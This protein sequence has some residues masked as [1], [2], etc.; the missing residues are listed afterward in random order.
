VRRAPLL[1]A[2][3]VALAA[4][5]PARAA[6]PA[7]DALAAARAVA[8]PASATGTTTVEGDTTDATLEPFE[9]PASV[10]DQDASYAGSIWFRVTAGRSGRLV[11]DTCGS[12]GGP[13]VVAWSDMMLF[14]LLDLGDG[15]AAGC[16]GGA[17][18]A[19]AYIAF[20]VNQGVSYYVAVAH[21]IG[22]AGGPVTLHLHYDDTAPRLVIAGPPPLTNQ[23]TATFT[24]AGDPPSDAA[25]FQCALD[26]ALPTGCT[27]AADGTVTFAGL[28]EG[29]HTLQARVI[30]AAGNG[31]QP[32]TYGWTIDRTPPE[33]RITGFP[34]GA[35]SAASARI[36]FESERGATFGCSLDSAP[37]TPCAPPLLLDGL[38][39]GRHTILVVASDPAGNR[40]PSPATASWVV[41][42]PEPPRP[43]PPPARRPPL[44]G[45]EVVARWQ[46]HGR[47]T[48]ARVLKLT[49]A[50][51]GVTVTVR[52]SGA[53]CPVGR[54]SVTARRRGTLAVRPLLE[55]ASPRR[56][57]VLDVTV[58]RR[59]RTSRIVRYRFG[60]PGTVPARSVLCRS[61]PSASARP[62]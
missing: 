11:A 2:L 50:V 23:T 47:G 44:V 35:T 27:P 17:T 8:A 38:A 14:D 32:T 51:R 29:D 13:V 54:R 37:V 57:A 58:S 4:A 60:T 26:D 46:R 59:K 5:A 16:P 18:P 39:V 36:D 7:N 48:R 3:A 42:E 45:G 28:L 52:C 40:D 43:P 1:L 33:T 31:D 15:S 62:C 24:L 49:G 56:G 41:E 21:H 9:P 55:G 19:S 25:F 20:S 53:G 34:S 10:L 22:Q 61:S 12:A 6:P 30:D